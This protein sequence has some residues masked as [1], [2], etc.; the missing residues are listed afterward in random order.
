MAQNKTIK[1]NYIRPKLHKSR[2][3]TRSRPKLYKS[4]SRTRSNKKNKNKNISRSRSNSRL[5]R[6]D[7]GFSFRGGKKLK[8]GMERSDKALK[9]SPI[10][11]PSPLS[12]E[13]TDPFVITTYNDPFQ[14]HNFSRGV[15][16]RKIQMEKLIE[17]GRI[18]RE[19]E[20]DTQ[21]W[22]RLWKE[23]KEQILRKREE[24]QKEREAR[25]KAEEDKFLPAM[26]EG[27][28]N[29]WFLF[30]SD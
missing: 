6:Y 11:Y 17:E 30:E 14:S 12:N 24:W 2:S 15:D 28:P 13:G 18:E 8:G 1:K 10:I 27:G 25:L 29:H 16:N 9:T 26:I 20:T 5:S 4:K 22:Y 3:K 23:E 21:R 7:Y 19:K